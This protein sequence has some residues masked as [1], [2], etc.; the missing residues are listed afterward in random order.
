MLY[1]SSILLSFLLFSPFLSY[2]PPLP[3]SHLPPSSIFPYHPLLFL[4]SH[5]IPPL[6][7]HDSFYTCRYL[8][9]LIYILPSSTN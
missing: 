5:S 4:P 9:I 1:S 6:P 8:Y 3:L 2:L 7:I